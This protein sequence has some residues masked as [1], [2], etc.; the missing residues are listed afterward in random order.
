MR[1]GKLKLWMSKVQKLN[2]YDNFVVLKNPQNPT[3][4]AKNCENDD[5]QRIVT[6]IEAAQNKNRP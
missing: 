5:Y 3:I 4:I 1:K 6:V 2:D